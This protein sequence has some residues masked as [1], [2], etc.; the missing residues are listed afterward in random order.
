V[1]ASC[2][3]KPFRLYDGHKDCLHR[4]AIENV[5]A[6]RPVINMVTAKALGIDVPPGLLA[7]ASEVIK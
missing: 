3:E 6:L 2:R 5:G 7:S 1:F 4:Q